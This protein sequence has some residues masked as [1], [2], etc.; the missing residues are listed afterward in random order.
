MKNFAPMLGLAL[1]PWLWAG[2]ALAQA[3]PGASAA[4]PVGAAT[5]TESA[6][7]VSTSALGSL[8]QSNSDLQSRGIALDGWLQADVSSVP[9]GGQPAADPVSGQYLLDLSATVDTQKLFGWSGGTFFADAQFH[10][11]NNI[12]TSQMPAIQDPDNMDASPTASID[13][14]WYQQKMLD[15]KLQVQIGLM[16]VDDQF[17]TVP[18]GQNFVSLN[19]SSDASISTFV[20]PTYPK[21]SYGA[22]VFVYPVK[23]LY[24]SA[25]AFGDHSTELPYDPGGRLYITEEGWQ[26]H[27]G[28]HAYTIQAGAWRDTGTFRRFSNTAPRAGAAGMYAVVSGQLWRPASSSSRGLGLFVQVGTAPAAVAPVRRHYGAGLVWTGPFARRSKD[29]I[30]VAFSDG[31]LTRQNGFTYG[32]EKEFEAYYRIQVA[33]GLTLQPDVEYWRHPNGSD[34]DTTLFLVRFQYSFGAGS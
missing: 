32:F 4:V 16:Y 13:R 7:P 10:G 31:L 29:E 33:Q 1:A 6:S 21:G 18:Y 12:V 9:A 14:A 23:G 17:L 34:R 28:G 26:G 25:G 2:P 3:E 24:L 30:G 15:Q 20:L 22:D 19:F 8:Q 5:V 11:G 27:W